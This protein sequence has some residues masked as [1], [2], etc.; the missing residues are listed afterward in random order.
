MENLL[1]RLRPELRT[2]IEQDI[3]KNPFRI[4]ELTEELKTKFY[5]NDVKYMHII[6]LE[7]YYYLT[8]G[9]L[10]KNAWECLID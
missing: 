8:F 2:I 3:D 6:D 5:M 1:Q 4:A 7:N 10:P 9:F